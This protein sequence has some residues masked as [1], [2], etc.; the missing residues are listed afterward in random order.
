MTAI[1]FSEASAKG[2][3]EGE[4]E[5]EEKEARTKMET[6]QVSEARGGGSGVKTGNM[7][8]LIKPEGT[9]GTNRAFPYSCLFHPE[10]PHACVAP[11]PD[12]KKGRGQKKRGKLWE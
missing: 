12:L 5:C 1:D 6:I 11:R 9:E 3:R 2:V 10:A 4:R 7:D 8:L